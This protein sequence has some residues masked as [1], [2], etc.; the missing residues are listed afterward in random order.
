MR[1]AETPTSS[2]SEA[3][4]I[5]QGSNLIEKT[6]NPLN[7]KNLFAAKYHQPENYE[8]AHKLAVVLHSSG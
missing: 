1:E 5:P 3:S 4:W 8:H 2:C 7:E 6:M